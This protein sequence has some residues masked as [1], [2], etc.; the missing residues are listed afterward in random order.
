MIKIGPHTIIFL[1][2]SL[3]VQAE[4]MRAKK[5]SDGP[6][7]NSSALVAPLA[8]KNRLRLGVCVGEGR[9]TLSPRLAIGHDVSAPHLQAL[10]EVL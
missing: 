5:R 2:S 7:L 3:A 1:L 9:P 8:P 10:C 4:A 6:L